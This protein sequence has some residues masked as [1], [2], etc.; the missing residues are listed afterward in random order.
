[1]NVSAKSQKKKLRKDR[2]WNGKCLIKE[3]TKTKPS[4]KLS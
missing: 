1:M 3:E 4:L 2:R